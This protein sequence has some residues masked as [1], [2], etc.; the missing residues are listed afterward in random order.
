MKVTA[1]GTSAYGD[2]DEG[3]NGAHGDGDKG[4]NGTGTA[5]GGEASTI[6][7]CYIP[8]AMAFPEACTRCRLYSL[9]GGGGLQ[10]DF[11]LWQIASMQILRRR[12]LTVLQII[13]ETYIKCPKSE[14]IILLYLCNM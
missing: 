10:S 5:S 4:T 1:T 11:E 3:T 2:G 13:A 9:P 7:Y 14:M 6:R 12:V 8:V